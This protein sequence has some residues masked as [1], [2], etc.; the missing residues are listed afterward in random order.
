M[1]RRVAAALLIVSASV[2]GCGTDPLVTLRGDYV[3]NGE[4]SC[5]VTPE[6]AEPET[7]WFTGT[8]EIGEPFSPSADGC[9][10]GMTIRGPAADCRLCLYDVRHESWV[11]GTLI[12]ATV[13][14]PYPD[15]EVAGC[16]LE[17][18]RFGPSTLFFSGYEAAG[19]LTLGGPIAD[20]R[21]SLSFDWSGNS[22]VELGGER[23][24]AQADCA[25]VAVRAE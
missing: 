6:G 20:D 22:S 19:E 21:F 7:V 8:V 9:E 14:N 17:R 16:N 15:T 12:A 25:L 1:T 18:D 5:T 23:T 3:V 24:R 10:A 13:G 2:A 4:G 11:G